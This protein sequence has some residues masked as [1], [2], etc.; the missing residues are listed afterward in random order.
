MLQL[1]LTTGMQ[2]GH[3]L[4]MVLQ[5]D[6]FMDKQKSSVWHVP[7]FTEIHTSSFIA[8]PVESFTGKWSD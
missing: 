1:L 8:H 7:T 6:K 4:H 2:L 5:Q 3:V